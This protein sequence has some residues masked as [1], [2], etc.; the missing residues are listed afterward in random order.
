MSFTG[1]V[2]R[3]DFPD[4]H[5]YIGSTK[6][7]LSSRLA[8]HKT[9]RL[10]NLNGNLKAGYIPRT[11]FD[12]YLAKHGWNN[13]TITSIK[14]VTV[15]N[16]SELHKHEYE[17]MQPLFYDA[18]N[19]NDRC[20]GIPPCPTEMQRVCKLGNLLDRQENLFEQWRAD[21]INEIL[22]NWFTSSLIPSSLPWL[23]KYYS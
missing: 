4:G 3:I 16:A 15:N 12:I 2:Y 14:K 5:F 20:P 9:Q 21:W 17:I 19:L 8:G 23:Q 13:P 10:N 6:H 18:K 22:N 7:A 1:E 11:R